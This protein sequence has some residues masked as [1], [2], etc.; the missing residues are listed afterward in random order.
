M[1]VAT[2]CYDQRVRI[3]LIKLTMD[4]RE[5]SH[6]CLNEL[7]IMDK[8]LGERVNAKGGLYDDDILDD[9]AL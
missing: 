1:I 5:E 8:P 2:G 6:Q 3:W 4:G 7:S 9:A